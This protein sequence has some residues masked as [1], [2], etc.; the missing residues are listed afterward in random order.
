MQCNKTFLLILFLL[1][2][3]SPV[4]TQTQQ[5]TEIPRDTS[6]TPYSSW[7]H[8]RDA[9]PEARIVEP[10]LPQGVLESRDVVY[11]T[12]PETPFGKRDLHVDVF[13][14]KI[15]GKYPA[16]MLVHGGGWVTG[17]RSMQVP[18]AQQIA[19]RG[20]V[21][22]VVEYQLADE[23]LYPAAI[24][25][26]KAA[27]R[28]ARANA[29]Q[30]QI[31]PE[32]I[33]ISGCSAGGQL[34]ALVGMTNGVDKF[35]GDQGN[36]DFSSGVQAVLDIDGVVDF[37]APSS[38]QIQR[39]PNTYDIKWFGGTFLEKPEI[40]MDASPI[41]WANEHSVP[42]LFINSGY[43]RFHAGQDEM[44]GMMKRWNI[45]TEVHTVDVLVHPFWLF[46]PWFEPTV[47]YMVTFLQKTLPK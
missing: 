14:P 6:Y 44:L 3:L 20:Y 25:N 8:I 19:A 1:A 2:V 43:P 28:W 16:L 32:Q 21:T 18:L 22:I 40:W 34:A 9:F 30:Y 37:L 17:N 13:R 42:V 39:K 45:Y 23:A 31:N 15:S 7:L 26:I 38:L 29:A 11:A 12:L 33:A 35:E 36:P 4:F 47:E 5:G 27:I 10:S 24:H 41:F 46:H